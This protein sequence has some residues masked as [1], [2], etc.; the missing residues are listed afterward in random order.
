[1]IHRDRWHGVELDRPDGFAVEHRRGVLTVRRDPCGFTAAV[2]WPVR[3]PF[4][5]SSEPLARHFIAIAR[6]QDPSFTAY[7]AP[8]T[9]SEGGIHLR[10]A[11]TLLGRRLEGRFRVAAKDGAGVL[12]GFQAPPEELHAL[13]PV[14]AKVLSSVK[15]TPALPRT[16]FQDPAEGAFAL[17]IPQSWRASGGILRIA[18]TN[19]LPRTHFEATDET[20]AL[21]AVISPDLLVFSEPNPMGAFGAMFGGM[22]AFMGPQAPQ[23]P[24]RPASDFARDFLAPRFR[25]GARIEYSHER[26]DL[27]QAA[28]AEYGSRG[29][30]GQVDA[31]TGVIQLVHDE[32][33][34]ARRERT[35]IHLIRI[36]GSGQ[37]T[38]YVEG[39]VSAPVDR[40]EEGEPVLSGIL[41]SF[42]ENP[43]WRVQQ[44]GQMNA[45][46]LQQ[47]QERH[48]R[49]RD[50]GRTLSETNDI[51]ASGW[52]ARQQVYDRASQEWSNA[53]LG[54]Q[55]MVDQSGQRW[56][57]PAGHEQ[58]WRDGL[59][60]V[61]AGGWLAQPDPTWQR[62]DPQSR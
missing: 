1:M 25:P 42:H 33:G 36:R 22:A 58:Y 9:D 50:I 24:F 45:W 19:G 52:H 10:T 49:L 30:L 15:A 46:L 61:Y 41:D 47:Q 4:A 17:G 59:G 16:I 55:D 18:A 51:I 23:L 27:L 48:A 3:G 62:L 13:A 53:M 43:Q 20:G 57:V 40:W 56:S 29:L 34:V 54:R 2:V 8:G 37:W 60:N 14:L 12:T 44:D 7:R 21:K 32:R 31:S 35:Q 28:L 11:G 5:A 26:P 38:C 6:A 39:G